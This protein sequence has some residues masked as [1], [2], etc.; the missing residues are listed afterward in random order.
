[1]KTFYRGLSRIGFIS[2]DKTEQMYF[3]FPRQPGQY[4]GFTVNDQQGNIPVKS[5]FATMDMDIHSV[6]INVRYLK[7]Q[8]FL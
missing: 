3:N 5:A 8:T 2:N 6:F 7:V 1:M 4:K